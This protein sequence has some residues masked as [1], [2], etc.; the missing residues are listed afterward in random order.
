MYIIKEILLLTKSSLLKLFAALLA[1]A[2]LFLLAY[3]SNFDKDLMIIIAVTI[4]LNIFLSFFLFNLPNKIWYK[5]L[6]IKKY[7][8]KVL[9]ISFRA[10]NKELERYDIDVKAKV[11]DYKITSDQKIIFRAIF[12]NGTYFHFTIGLF[13]KTINLSDRYGRVYSVEDMALTADREEFIKR[14]EDIQKF[15]NRLSDLVDASISCN[16]WTIDPDSFNIKKS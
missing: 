10:Y 3:N 14:F 11:N 13:T 16:N 8:H 12:D 9:N 6:I 7:L 5:K 4:I 1:V 15:K 2:I